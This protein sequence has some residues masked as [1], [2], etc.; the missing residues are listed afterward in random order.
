MRLRA[1]RG[2]AS[3]AAGFE[4]RVS[5]MRWETAVAAEEGE[6]AMVGSASRLFRSERVTRHVEL[7]RWA[8]MA[9]ITGVAGAAGRRIVMA[10]ESRRNGKVLEALPDGREL[11]REW[12][13]T[14]TQVDAQGATCG[15]LYCW[16]ACATG[17]GSRPIVVWYNG[18]NHFKAVTRS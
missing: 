7:R 8:G 4:R 2:E 16:G 3:E 15:E 10:D 5:W 6:D 13:A 9:Q 17:H 11:E 14:C 18:V 12:C 1:R